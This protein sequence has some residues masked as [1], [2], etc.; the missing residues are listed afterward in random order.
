MPIMDKFEHRRLKL[1][2]LMNE[3]CNGN[4]A[5]LAK[6]LKC[7]DSY[8]AR[9]L[10][11]EGKAGKKRIGEDWADRIAEAFNLDRSALE[12]PMAEGTLHR[13]LQW[14]NTEE[15]ELLTL[16]RST[17][18]EGRASIMQVAKI[19]PKVLLTGIVRNQS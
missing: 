8:A 19:V 5:E 15:N 2:A 11:P 9:M 10:Y 14:T 3:Q 7:S 13:E 6:K 18:N 1:I 16:F 17:D 12:L 4:K